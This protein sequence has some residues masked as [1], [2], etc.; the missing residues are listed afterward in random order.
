[1]ENTILD[2]ELVKYDPRLG[3]HA[4][5]HTHQ[6]TIED[7]DYKID[8]L[9]SYLNRWP[10]TIKKTSMLSRRKTPL[11]LWKFRKCSKTFW[12]IR[13]WLYQEQVFLHNCR[14]WVNSTNA[15]IGD[16]CI[17]PSDWIFG[18][19]NRFLPWIVAIIWRR[20]TRPP[21]SPK[22]SRGA[23]FR[24]YPMTHWYTSN[25]WQYKPINMG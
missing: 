16:M 9:K 24:S 20:S 22:R 11:P 23:R 12:K 2:R 25:V 15:H 13:P 10:D 17:L 5:A 3:Y 1:L 18:T 6:F 8:I 21:A 19:H 14:S 4:E 7:F